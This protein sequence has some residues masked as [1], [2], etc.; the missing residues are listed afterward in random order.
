MFLTCPSCNKSNEIIRYFIWKDYPVFVHCVSC[1]IK[2]SIHEIP[3]KEY[4]F[5]FNIN[6]NDNHYN[7][8]FQANEIRINIKRKTD[9]YYQ[10]IPTILNT[11]DLNIQSLITINPTHSD[12]QKNFHLIYQFYKDFALNLHLF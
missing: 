2:F 7:L 11:N 1:E 9:I 4:H 12:I 10:N 5:E 3:S 6:N 8:Y